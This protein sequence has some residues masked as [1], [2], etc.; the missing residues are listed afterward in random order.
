MLC[1]LEPCREQDQ[2]RDVY[3]NLH[4]N[5]EAFVLQVFGEWVAELKGMDDMNLG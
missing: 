3:N 1:Y 2:T 4:G 5:M